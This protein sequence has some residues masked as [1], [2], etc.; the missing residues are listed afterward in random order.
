MSLKEEGM[1]WRAIAA[2]LHRPKSTVQEFWMRYQERRHEQN[3]LTP[4]RPQKLNRRARRR[5]PFQ[6]L[7]NDVAPGASVRTVK[8]MLRKETIC[9]WRAKKRA[10]LT[11]DHVPKHLAWAQKYSNLAVDDWEGVIFSDECAVEKPKDPRTI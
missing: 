7:R 9:K 5:I 8:R 6:E 11:P 1:S 2:R 3:L 4:G 10:L